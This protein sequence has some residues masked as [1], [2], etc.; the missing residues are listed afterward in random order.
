MIEIGTRITRNGSLNS[1]GAPSRS[2]TRTHQQDP[3]M[4]KRFVGTAGS[5]TFNAGAGQIQDAG[6]PANFVA[7]DMVL[8]EGDGAANGTFMVT[9]TG[10]GYLTTSPAPPTGGGGSTVITIRTP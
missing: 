9:G 1:A 10:S 2:E 4:L 6:L 7:G 8:C 3:S 5:T